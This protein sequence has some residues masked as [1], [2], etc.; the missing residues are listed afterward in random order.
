MATIHKRRL[1]G[2]EVVWELTHG[3]GT[4]RQRFI[5][6]KTR[7]EAQ[8]ILRQFERQ[9]SLHGAAPKDETVQGVVGQYIKYLKT[10][11]RHGTVRRYVRVLTTFERC[12]LARFYPD[13]NRLRQIRPGHLEEYKA[14]RLEGGDLATDGTG[15]TSLYQHEAG[16]G[17]ASADLVYVDRV[18][19]SFLQ[20]VPCAVVI[21]V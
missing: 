14:R 9:I 16:A 21:G 2:G 10:N 11:R 17:E 13:V 20:P 5:V 19:R 12:F 8:A 3:T 15:S 1:R 4:D 6:G 18:P 7:E